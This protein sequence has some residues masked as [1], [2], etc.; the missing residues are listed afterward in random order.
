L[1]P[2]L[3]ATRLDL[4]AA[5][6]DGDAA[7]QRGFRLSRTPA[8]S[9]ILVVE[10]AVT[11]VLLVGSGLLVRSFLRLQEIDIGFNADNVATVTVSIPIKRVRERTEALQFFQHLTERVA[12]LP[13]VSSAGTTSGVPLTHRGGRTSHVLEGKPV[14]PAPPRDDAASGAPPMPPP[15]PPPKGQKH[16]VVRPWQTPSTRT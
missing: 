2:A 7:S 5:L 16:A 10:I 12:S 11:L 13:G 15:P 14:V 4:T 3:H 6:R 8:R 9:V 1:A